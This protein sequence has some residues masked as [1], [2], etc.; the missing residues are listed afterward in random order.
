MTHGFIRLDL[1]EK[2]FEIVNERAKKLGKTP[3]NL[4]R[5]LLD[6]P[7]LSPEEP[8]KGPKEKEKDEKPPKVERKVAA[9]RPDVKA[10]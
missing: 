1:S 3:Y 8:V 10:K 5:S 6:L 9:K 4:L 7:E 2:E